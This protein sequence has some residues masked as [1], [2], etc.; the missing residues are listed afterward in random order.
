MLELATQ[1]FGNLVEIDSACM[2]GYIDSTTMAQVK[3][4]R[5]EYGYDVPQV[6]GAD[7]APH[8][9]NWD[10]T[11]FVAHELPKIFLARPG[12]KISGVSNYQTVDF[13]SRGF[14][15]TDV[16][17]EVRRILDGD[18]PVNSLSGIVHEKVLDYILSHRLFTDIPHEQKILTS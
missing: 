8:M 7:V 14:S 13:A 15:S 10:K 9:A 4:L 12:Y 1:E 2:D 16:R 5:R 6:F 18:S 11:G 17:R 3:Y